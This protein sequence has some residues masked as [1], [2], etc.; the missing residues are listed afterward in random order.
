MGFLW[1]ELFVMLR[2]VLLL[3]DILYENVC[4]LYVCIYKIVIGYFRDFGKL[5]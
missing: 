3:N 5:F 2:E 4:M 1:G